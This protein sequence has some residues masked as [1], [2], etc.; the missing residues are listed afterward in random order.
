M[1]LGQSNPLEDHIDCHTERGR[2]DESHGTLHSRVA[3][4]QTHLVRYKEPQANT[5]ST[6]VYFL[7]ETEWIHTKDV[8]FGMG[9]QFHR[10]IYSKDTQL[11]RCTRQTLLTFLLH[12][13]SLHSLSNE[14]VHEHL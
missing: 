10:H 8:T 2:D 3:A 12:H 5:S 13:S 9:P 11:P 6:L 4:T 1:R 7:T 14:H